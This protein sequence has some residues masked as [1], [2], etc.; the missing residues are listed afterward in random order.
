[1]T[2]VGAGTVREEGAFI[3]AMS[4]RNA[5]GDAGSMLRMVAYTASVTESPLIPKNSFINRSCD[6]SSVKEMPKHREVK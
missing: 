1:M 4:D 2:G 3:Q 6:S 5:E